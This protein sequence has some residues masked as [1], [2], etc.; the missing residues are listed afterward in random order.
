MGRTISS[1]SILFMQAKS[2]IL[3]FQRGLSKSDQR[4]IDELFIDANK[5][6]AEAA[7][8]ASPIP[9]DSFLLAM[10]LEIHKKVLEL[11]NLVDGE[12]K[13]TKDRK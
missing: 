1:V 6:I 11:G 13:D 5:H 7:Y 12:S 2:D 4:V 8:A 3:P 9:M 10:L